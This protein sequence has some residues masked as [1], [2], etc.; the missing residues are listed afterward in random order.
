MSSLRILHTIASWRW[1]GAAEPM[2]GIAL[3][4]QRLGHEVWVAC[5]GGS[6]LEQQASQMGLRVVTEI[7][8]L[9]RRNPLALW[10]QVGQ[11]RRFL[12]AHDIDVLHTHIAHDHWV[13]GFACRGMD[14]ER[15]PL[16]ARSVHR[17]NF[18]RDP[19]H[20]W[21]FRRTDLLFGVTHEQIA[22]LQK[23]WGLS[24]DCVALLRGAIDLDRFRPEGDGSH[25]RARWKI[26]GGAPV[27]GMIGRM[28]PGRGH[29][30]LLEAAPLILREAPE[31]HIVLCG[32]GDL[33]R[34]VR[35]RIRAMPERSHLRAPGYV[36]TENLEAV[37]H[38]FDVVLY[39]GVGSD[40]TSRGLLEAMASGRPIVAV[41]AAAVP[42]MIEDGVSG[43]LVEPGDAPGLAR[44]VLTLLRDPA[45]AAA[46]GAA[47]RCA[48]E[49][50]HREDHRA[51]DIC[52]AYA[53]AMKTKP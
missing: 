53:R 12:E 39:L 47:A 13:A 35:H 11:M 7:D 8:F 37:Y 27:A 5:V 19:L 20:D 48:A 25:L 21:L 16:L 34:E 50:R 41:R 3:H 30:W 40:K 45:R 23:A 51:R 38:A 4:Q 32:R 33:K 17:L 52:A 10:A 43:L 36:P 24:D 29:L 49:S 28:R 46:L 42:D 31:A 2:A 18:R 1:T 26:P 14:P 6:S 9:P 22:R 44:A 15:R